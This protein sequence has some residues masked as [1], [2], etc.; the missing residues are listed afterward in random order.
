[1][2]NMAKKN[3]AAPPRDGT[4]ASVRDA[5]RASATPEPA[6]AERPLRRTFT[7]EYKQRILRE[8]EAAAASGVSGAVGALLRKEGLYSSHL[9]E[10]RRERDRGELA[11]LTPKKRGRKPTPKNPMADE[12][13]QLRRQN[14][15]LQAELDKAKNII[16]VQHKLSSLLGIPMPEEPPEK[17]S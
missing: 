10:W 7:A 5:A 1:M 13:E 15:R 8:S 14:A 11:G 4:A 16:D 17:K 6:T 12:L 3:G 9:T 2:L